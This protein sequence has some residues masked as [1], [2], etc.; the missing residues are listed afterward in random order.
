MYELLRS[1]DPV[2]LSYAEAMLK[3]E[4]IGCV[5]LDENT[6]ALY[7]GI[8]AIERRLMVSSKDRWRA[9]HVLKAADI[10]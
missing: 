6:S 5:I 9:K 3:A 1:A 7:I 4:E 8:M 10:L 2:L